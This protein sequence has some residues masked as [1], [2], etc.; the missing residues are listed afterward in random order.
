MSNGAMIA[1]WPV[2]SVL[3]MPLQNVHAIL[4]QHTEDGM[5]ACKVNTLRHAEAS[6]LAAT[7]L[8]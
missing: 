3:M 5:H 6:I 1:M 8:S 7:P 2:F 4:Y